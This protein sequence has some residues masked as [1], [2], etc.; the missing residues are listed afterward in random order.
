MEGGSFWVGSWA[1][2]GGAG[3]ASRGCFGTQSSFPVGLEGP[4]RLRA[5]KG[6]DL[7]M[8]PSSE[9]AVRSWPQV[10]VEAMGGKL[11]A[12]TTRPVSSLAQPLLPTWPERP[13]IG[14]SPRCRCGVSP[15]AQEG[16]WS[17]RL[18]SSRPHPRRA[19][20]GHLGMVAAAGGGAG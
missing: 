17:S 15:S 9:D 20:S 5:G 7:G 6:H 4:G 8:C 13:Q 19:S 3:A 2:L 16:W 18:G 14:L 11:D 1:A 12:S 10:A